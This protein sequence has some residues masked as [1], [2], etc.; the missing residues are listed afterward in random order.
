MLNQ[1]RFYF[2]YIFRILA[3]P[4]RA[5]CKLYA[6]R[7]NRASEKPQTQIYFKSLIWIAAVDLLPSIVIRLFEEQILCAI[8]NN[9]WRN[10]EWDLLA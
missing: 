5:T 2:I 3:E 8:V 4:P 10:P 7:S 6:C 1:W 9:S